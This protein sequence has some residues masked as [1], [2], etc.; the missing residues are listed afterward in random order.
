[1]D[2]ATIELFEGI[3]PDALRQ[4]YS[5]ASHRQFP[6]GSVICREDEPGNSMFIIEH[7]SAVVTVAGERVRRLRAGDVI[8]EI[9]VLTGEPRS[10]T[11]RAVLPTDVIELHRDALSAVLAQTPQLLANLTRVLSRRLATAHDQQVASRRGEAV[12]LAL[13]ESLLASLKSVT[14]ACEAASPKPVAFL[15]GGPLESTLTQLDRALSESAFVFVPVELRGTV[16]Q[17]LDAHMDRVVAV[18]RDE[19]EAKAAGVGRGTDADVVVLDPDDEAKV[20]WLGRHLTRTK[21]GLALGAGGAKGFAHVGAVAVLQEAGYAFDAV[22]GSSIGAVVGA[23]LAMGM[24][25]PEIDATLRTRFS[26]ETVKAVFN[27]SFSGTSTGYETMKA[28]TSEL[29]GGR[30]FADLDLPLTVMTVDLATR[31]PV[32]ITDGSLADALLA[33]TA[34]AGLFPPFQR[35]DQR[36]V[37][38]LALVPVP[39]DSARSLGAD[40]VVSVNLMSRDTLAAWPGDEPLPPEPAGKQRLLETMLEVMDLAQLDASVRHAAKADVAVTPRFGPCSWRDF[41]L[42][43]RFLAAGREAMQDML[44]ALQG[45]ARPQP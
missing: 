15:D 26:E 28:L 42:A 33:G 41:H 6:A 29:A 36:L 37:D 8:G 20:A 2:L 22:A 17:T 23:C 43:D 40:V 10:A 12:G 32:P 13:S 4:V 3:G 5:R 34:L 39:T 44:P 9:A 35:G 38:G 31:Q 21:V 27:L 19:A 14:A 1:M 45:V 30:S 25:A 7:G 16:L 11:V 24:A 18:V